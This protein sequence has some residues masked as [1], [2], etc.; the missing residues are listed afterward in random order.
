M[1]GWAEVKSQ[2]RRGKPEL[3]DERILGSGDFV[4]RVIRE[5]EA[6]MQRQYTARERPTGRAFDCRGMQETQSIADRAQEREPP[7]CYSGFQRT[8]V[9]QI[10]RRYGIPIAE[11]ARQVGVS[12]SAISKSLPT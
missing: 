10:S 6:R 8:R 12:T 2:R 1:G 11:V 4:E 5:A 9:A 3:A 7:R